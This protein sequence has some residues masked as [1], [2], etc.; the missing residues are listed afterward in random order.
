MPIR[1]NLDRLVDALGPEEW[2]TAL[3]YWR[4]RG[5]S[6][7]QAPR[8]EAFARYLAARQPI[9]LERARAIVLRGAQSRPSRRG[10]DQA[11]R[12]APRA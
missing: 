10:G 8:V 9:G 1:Q 4:A 5:L 6:D 11:G 7:E 3:T 2:H 12:E